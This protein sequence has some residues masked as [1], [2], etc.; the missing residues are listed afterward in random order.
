MENL[1]EQL[2]QTITPEYVE[3]LTITIR[4]I[5]QRHTVKKKHNLQIKLFKLNPRIRVQM[6]GQHVQPL[7][8]YHRTQYSTE[9]LNY[10]A[11]DAN[12]LEFFAV[13][14]GVF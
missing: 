10:N 14:E 6:G 13:L 8:I 1:K 5:P 3:R 9:G 4:S 7:T 12:K 2:E 11:H